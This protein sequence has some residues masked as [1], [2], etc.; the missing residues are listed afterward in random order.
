MQFAKKARLSTNAQHAWLAHVAWNV[1]RITRRSQAVLVSVPAA[2]T[3]QSRISQIPS[4]IKV[5]QI[6][7][8]SVLYLFSDFDLLDE[9]NTTLYRCRPNAKPDLLRKRDKLKSECYQR[10][11]HLKLM[12]HVFSMA[13]KNSST[14]RSRKENVEGT[15][16]QSVSTEILWRT[17]WVFTEISQ[18][19]SDTCVSET[20]SIRD[21]LSRFF[22]DS[23]KLGPT[24]HMFANTAI[25]S[26]D[27]LNVFLVSVTKDEVPM[28]L[29]VPLREALSGQSFIEY[30]VFHI[31]S[32]PKISDTLVSSD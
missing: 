10:N 20:R 26:V 7:P 29:D 18:T 8:D 12:P 11:I 31:H 6:I 5:R 32:K 27:D 13:Q 24:R 28:N 19:L 17:E 1:S 30:P 3:Y 23:W 14:I 25:D 2:R 21:L 22:D 15:E 16:T 9:A 4:S